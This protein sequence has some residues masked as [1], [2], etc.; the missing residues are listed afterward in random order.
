MD[1][2]CEAFAG[3]PFLSRQSLPTLNALPNP[4]SL[5]NYDSGHL[6]NQING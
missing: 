1:A 3:A 2:L 4:A 6:E 5:I